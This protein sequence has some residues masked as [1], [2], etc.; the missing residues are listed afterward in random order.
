MLKN[1]IPVLEEN[2]G[3]LFSTAETAELIGK[4]TAWLERNRCAGTGIP[5][6]KIGRM[7]YYRGKDLFIYV[8]GKNLA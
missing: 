6:D 2:Q 1:I 4:S 5:Y 7:P 3:T 8:T